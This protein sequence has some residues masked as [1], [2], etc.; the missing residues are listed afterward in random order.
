MLLPCTYSPFPLVNSGLPEQPLDGE[1]RSGIMRR[2][3]KKRSAPLLQ[4]F[5]RYPNPLWIGVWQLVLIKVHGTHHRTAVFLLLAVPDSVFRLLLLFERCRKRLFLRHSD[6]L[7]LLY[8]RDKGSACLR[9]VSASDP[10]LPAGI[11]EDGSDP[12]WG[13]IEAWNSVPLSGPHDPPL[14]LGG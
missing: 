4:D 12:S 10:N 13:R 11:N 9:R 5:N 3:G 2:E 14:F 8:T 6:L 1:D 7:A